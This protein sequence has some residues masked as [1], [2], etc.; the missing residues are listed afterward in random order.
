M[1]LNIAIET[2]RPSNMIKNHKLARSIARAG[3]RQFTNQLEYKAQPF[4]KPN[5]FGKN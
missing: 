4:A 5:G 2:L 3:W 1:I